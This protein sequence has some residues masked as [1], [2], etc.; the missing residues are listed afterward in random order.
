MA[1]QS[2]TATTTSRYVSNIVNEFE[3]IQ[4]TSIVSF[5]KKLCIRCYIMVCPRNGFESNSISCK[6]SSIDHNISVK[7]KFCK[8]TLFSILRDIYFFFTQIFVKTT[9]QRT[10]SGSEIIYI[11]QTFKHR[12]HQYDWL[13]FTLQHTF[14]P[15]RCRGLTMFKSI[16][17]INPVQVKPA[18]GSNSLRLRGHFEQEVSYC[19][20][21]CECIVI[22]PSIVYQQRIRDLTRRSGS[23][24]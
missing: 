12:S 14:C 22:R 2:Q 15:I 4:R 11:F 20:R 19:F 24:V 18:S 13:M 16:F 6:L 7:D 10:G 3:P 21:Y 9:S 1:P 8:W 23:G 5:S 17:I